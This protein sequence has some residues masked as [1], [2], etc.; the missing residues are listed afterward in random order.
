LPFDRYFALI[1]KQDTTSLTCECSYMLCPN[2]ENFC[3]NNG[4]FFSVVDAAASLCRTFMTWSLRALTIRSASVAVMGI[5]TPKC[6]SGISDGMR[7]TSFKRSLKHSLHLSRM[8]PRCWLTH[9]FR[10][11]W[12]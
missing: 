6:I 8:P 5:S 11:W 7:L 2:V 12:I 4:Q 1:G 3:P 10:L 9:G